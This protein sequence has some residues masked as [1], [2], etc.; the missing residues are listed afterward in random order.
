M[1]STDATMKLPSWLAAQ[2]PEAAG[3]A[4]LQECLKTDVHRQITAE[5]GWDHAYMHWAPSED[6]Q[7]QC[8]Y[9]SVPP[10]CGS[11]LET[12][13]MCV[14][15][16]SSQSRHIT[17][18]TFIRSTNTGGCRHWRKTGP[19]GNGCLH[20]SASR[21][22]QAISKAKH[23]PPTK[24]CST[25]ARFKQ[26]VQLCWQSRIAQEPLNKHGNKTRVYIHVLYTLWNHTCVQSWPKTPHNPP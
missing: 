20:T 15:L 9:L 17:M 25:T 16:A 12:K 24:L 6:N 23:H 8:R 10:L 7:C 11:T 3:A 13:W 1:L 21:H 14:Q 18:H 19:E 22:I 5:V 4:L 2:S 26:A